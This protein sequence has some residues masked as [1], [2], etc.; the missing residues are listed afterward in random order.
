MANFFKEYHAE[1]KAQRTAEEQKK[2]PRRTEYTT[3]Q[4]VYIDP[5]YDENRNGRRFFVEYLSGDSV[6]LAKTKKDA[7]N[8]YGYIYSRHIMKEG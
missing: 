1:L 3:G 8:G 5:M 4:V 6:L 2:N 7:L